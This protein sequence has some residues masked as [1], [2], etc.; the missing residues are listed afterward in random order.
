MSD[1]TA[2]PYCDR[3]DRSVPRA[4]VRCPW[5]HLPVECLRHAGPRRSDGER[6]PGLPAVPSAARGRG[7]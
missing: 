3:C 2:P 1:P 6:L 7:P 4:A 5:C